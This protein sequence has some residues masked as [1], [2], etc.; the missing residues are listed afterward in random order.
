MPE[1]M[2]NMDDMMDNMMDQRFRNAF[3]RAVIVHLQGF[4]Q[5]GFGFRETGLTSFS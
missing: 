3:H 5:K 2:A 4:A 1:V